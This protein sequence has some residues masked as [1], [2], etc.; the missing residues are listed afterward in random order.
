MSRGYQPVAGDRISV[1]LHVPDKEG[2]LEALAAR[3]FVPVELPA[4]ADEGDEPSPGD[5]AP[6][7]DTEG[8]GVDQPSGGGA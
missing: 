8:T 7:S 2:A 1:A 5:G 3:G 4:A 6:G